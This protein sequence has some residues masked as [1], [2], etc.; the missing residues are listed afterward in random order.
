[1]VNAHKNTLKSLI[2]VLIGE[3]PGGWPWGFHKI[4]LDC[5]K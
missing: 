3:S 1:M 5:K 4:T 2:Y